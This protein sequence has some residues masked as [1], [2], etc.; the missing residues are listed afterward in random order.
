MDAFWKV[1]SVLGLLVF[2]LVESGLGEAEAPGEVVEL[3]MV[4]FA[5]AVDDLAQRFEHEEVSAGVFAIEMFGEAQAGGEALVFLEFGQ[6]G[7]VGL[8]VEDVKASFGGG[9][10]CVLCYEQAVSFGWWMRISR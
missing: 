3:A 6:V 5:G 8:A 9:E 10:R 2:D 4:G 1:K 7:G